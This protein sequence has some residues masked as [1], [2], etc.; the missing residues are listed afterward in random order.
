MAAA[1]AYRRA[2]FLVVECARDPARLC[3]LPRGAPLSGRAH[4]Q[5]GCE[6][7]DARALA[8]DQF[9]RGRHH[10]VHRRCRDRGRSVAG[11]AL[12]RDGGGSVECARPYRTDARQRRGGCPRL[13]YGRRADLGLCRRAHGPADQS[14]RVR[15][16]VRRA[17]L[18]R[19]A[20]IRHPSGR[21]TLWIADR[22]GRRGP[23]GNDRF[24]RILEGIEAI[25]KTRPWI[26]S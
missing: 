13:S 25:Y 24:A 19:R 21:R 23:R 18:A 10:L 20:P 16:G 14:R 7:H 1:L 5:R 4:A 17:D 26:S 9:G 8:R 11:V 2:K 22:S 6:R 15:R 12:D 3:V